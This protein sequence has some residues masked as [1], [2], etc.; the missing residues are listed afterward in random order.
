MFA[1]VPV[2]VAEKQSQELKAA[3]GKPGAVPVKKRE[4]EVYDGTGTPGL[5]SS[6]TQT[7]T[8]SMNHP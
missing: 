8:V 5:N 1:A 2:A 4:D 7:W 6:M 3:A